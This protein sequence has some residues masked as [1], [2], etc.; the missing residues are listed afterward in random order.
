MADGE[1]AGTAREASVLQAAPTTG[2]GRQIGEAFADLHCNIMGG[3]V[4]RLR[5]RG[6]ES[7]P[8]QEFAARELARMEAEILHNEID[9]KKQGLAGD[10]V[11]MVVAQ[12]S[13]RGR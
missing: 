4:D 1:T 13:G 3:F 8:G 6:Q 9:P 5:A 7:L 10:A 11:A 2:N 12:E